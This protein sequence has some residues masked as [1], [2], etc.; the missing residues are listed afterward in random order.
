MDTLPPEIVNRH[1]EKA[2]PAT[3]V[4]DMA[5]LGK[6]MG[7]RWVLGG[8]VTKIGEKI[9]LDLKAVDAEGIKP[10]LLIYQV[11][12]GL[13]A[14]P[15]AADRIAK[16]LD[17]QLSGVPQIDSIRVKGNQRIEAAAIQAVV[18][19]KPG[20]RVD[21]ARL[22]KD[23]RSVYQMGFFRDV[24]VETEPGAKGQVVVFDV[25][26]KPSIGKILLEG[27]E[28]IDDE[29]LRK[30]LGIRL[31]SIL[32]RNQIKQSINRLKE[33]YRQKAF[34]NVEIEDHI[35]PIPNNQ[36]QVT[37]SITEHEKVYIRKIE[38]IGNTRFDDDDLADIMETSTKG[39]LSWITD[40]GLLDQKKLEFDAHKVTSFYHN[41]GFI[42]AKVGEP[43]VTRDLEKGLK[44]TIEIVEGAQYGVRDVSVEG[45]L[46][47]P[48]E[49]LLQDMKIRQEK[50]FNREAVRQDIMSLREIYAD[51]GYAYAEIAPDIREDNEVHLVDIVFKVSKGEKVR[52]GRIS[53]S[54]NTKT[55]D[56]V[57]RRELW[58]VEG[59]YFSGKA[60]KRS[61]LN[62]NR[63]GFF[64]EVDIKTE[65]SRDK[66]RM[67]LEVRVKEKPTG[68][69]S[70]GAGY[71]SQDKLL[72]MAK[73][74]QNNFMGY[75]V[76]LSLAV[77]IGGRSSEFDI[78]V[79]EP[80]LFGRPVSG[81]ARAFKWKRE[82]DDYTKDSLGG[83]VTAGAPMRVIDSFTRAWT[84][85]RYEDSLIE[86]VDDD[87]STVIQ[88]MVGRS[89]TSSITAGL[90]RNSTDRA[91]N[92]SRGSVNNISA[93]YAGGFLGGD[94]YFNKYQARSAWFFP[95]FW[96]M[97][98]SLQ[99]RGG[100][101]DQR[102]GGD[103]PV[104]E[105]FFLGG[106]NTVRGFEY[107]AISPVDPETGD[108]IGGEKMLCFNAEYRFPLLKSQGISGVLFFDAGNVW[109][110]EQAYNL[111]DVRMGAG[112]EIR[113]YSPMGPLRVAW[114]FNL[115]PIGDEPSNQ[116]D[117]TMGT[118]F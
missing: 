118:T 115:D 8:S 95:L 83:E 109:S 96:D 19:S 94:N 85:Y 72:G 106:I 90:V 97:V 27:N 114:G 47:R 84:R 1:A 88:D 69:F 79:S 37:Y 5:A 52:F 55:R 66:G 34:Y 3:D 68:A 77:K 28:E 50:V 31:Y 4:S 78:Q 45:D 62:L 42:K 108:K 58:T 49:I 70:F 112:G 74:D 51:D 23:L 110:V 98:F 24:K 13:D 87:A 14:L 36:V 99:G 20:D 63:L 91:W 81:D 25:T 75:G 41:H 32:D 101:I 61:S 53:I 39:W 92:P 67:D 60:L 29:D 12:E 54:G 33:V 102:P 57:I 105:K 48:P 22:D 35:T 59:Q 30:E 64:E 15:A 76:R 86:D 17:Y 56:K 38:F 46:I 107:A 18:R 89:V 71:S 104:Y 100:Y 113:W 21:D 2:G 10:P 7:A 40:S 103:L 73:V 116:V 16:T 11:A 65:K 9:S 26:E 82:Y 6:A 44:I 111:T 43:K 80:W 117:F 93:E